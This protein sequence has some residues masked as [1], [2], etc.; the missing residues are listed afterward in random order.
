MIDSAAS[1]PLRAW[2]DSCT[3]L[4]CWLSM[5][6]WTGPC[7]SVE[8]VDDL[9]RVEFRAERVVDRVDRVADVG[10]GVLEQ[11]GDLRADQRADR[12]DE[13]S[14]SEQHTEQDERGRAAASPA[15]SAMESVDPRL[16]RE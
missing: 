14:G 3:T 9:L 11:I 7:S 12:S 6:R 16:D 15:A 4:S 5:N 1:I 2:S 13:D 8:V 10:L